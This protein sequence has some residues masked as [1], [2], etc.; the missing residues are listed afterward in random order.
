MRR[1]ASFILSI[2]VLVASS[3]YAAPAP[4][5]AEMA[6]RQHFRIGEAHYSGGQFAEALTD[7]EAGYGAV[8]LP[9]FLVNIAQCHRRLGHLDEARRTYQKFVLVAPDSPLAPE[10]RGLIAELDKLLDPPPSAGGNLSAGSPAG[11]RSGARPS[12]AVDLRAPPPFVPAGGS[13]GLLD[14]NDSTAATTDADGERDKT[15]ASHWWFWG[16]VAAATVGGV[17]G[18]VALSPGSPSTIHDG[19]LGTLRR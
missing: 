11:T 16:A 1:A 5:E 18:I 8:P 13:R 4:P 15:R 9:G 10:V 3:A 12:G 7:Y 17:V 2:T 6:A 14:K 19:T